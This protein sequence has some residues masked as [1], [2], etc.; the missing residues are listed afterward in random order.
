MQFLLKKTHLIKDAL[1]KRYSKESDQD[2]ILL[3]SAGYVADELPKALI[4][5]YLELVNTKEV[6]CKNS[7]LK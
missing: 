2:K 3:L 7:F 1:S 4:P 5:A 6:N